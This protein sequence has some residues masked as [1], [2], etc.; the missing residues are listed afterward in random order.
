M[1]SSPHHQPLPLADAFA[2]IMALPRIFKTTLQNIPASVPYLL[3][4]PQCRAAWNRR[5]APRPRHVLRVGIAWQGNPRHDWDRFRSIPL[6]LLTPLTR[7][8][9]VQLVS[10]QRGPGTEQIPEFQRLTHHALLLPFD[11]A[12]VSPVD[13]ADAAA[14]IDSLDLVITVDS[15]P[16]H[17]AGALGKPAWVALSLAADWRWLTHRDDSPWYPSLRLFRQQS[18]GSWK[19]VI[20]HIAAELAAQPPAL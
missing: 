7:I 2:P 6:H 1:S 4:D 13:F 18:H 3:A 16:A 12:P 8:P 17:L 9:H 11:P 19:T 20:D 14:I 10:L 15:A 5:L